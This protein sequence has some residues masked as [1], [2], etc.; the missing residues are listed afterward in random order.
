MNSVNSSDFA[1]GHQKIPITLYCGVST[2][3][4]FC[5]RR[6]SVAILAANQPVTAPSGCTCVEHNSVLKRRLL[7]NPHFTPHL[8]CE[9]E[10]ELREVRGET[11]SAAAD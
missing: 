9:S 1:H 2:V 4:S 6:F 8:R 10:D 11:T 7:Q 5:C 3:V